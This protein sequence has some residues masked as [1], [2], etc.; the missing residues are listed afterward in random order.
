MR[1]DKMG[2]DN[3]FKRANDPVQYFARKRREY[4]SI[5]QKYCQGATSATIIGEIIC[6][7]LKEPIEQSVYKKTARD[8]AD[9]MRAKCKSLNGNRSNLEKHILKTLAEQEDFEAYLNYIH[10]PKEHFQSFIREEVKQY[11]TDNFNTSVQPKMRD[12][13]KWKEKRIIEAVNGATEVVNKHHGDADLWL[14]TFTLKLSDVL[15]FS[16][17]DLKGVSRDDVDVKILEEVMI[18]EIPSMI[19]G[20][21]KKFSTES[22]PS[23]LDYKDRPDEILNEH[24]CKCCWVQCPFCKVL[25]TNTAE[26]HDPQPHSVPFH[27]IDGLNGWHYSG[28]ED[29]S[30]GFC[31]TL[32]SSNLSFYPLNESKKAIKYKDY[33]TAG[34]VYAKWGITPD[35]TQ[36]SY[37]KWVV[38]R[39]QKD[40]ENYHK[41]KFQ[42]RGEIP[43]EWRR[44]TKL[45]A[46]ESLDKYI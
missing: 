19:S 40:L 8:L 43:S 17:N 4:Y 39:F 7:K 15:E 25:C 33:K 5:F 29:L 14:K 32:V 45:D 10:D 20:I 2:E 38:C 21:G 34:G 24:L 13:L 46:I 42:G 27:R 35:F 12:D 36:L 23:K 31:T 6:N 37:W 3:I 30:A 44:H 1:K 26:D 9:E 41:L 11:I 28:T 16:E 22:F 18:K